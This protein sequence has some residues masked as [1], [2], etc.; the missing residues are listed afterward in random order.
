MYILKRILK[1]DFIQ[2]YE[3]FR[4]NGILKIADNL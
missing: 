3:Y 1:K 2:T 4:L